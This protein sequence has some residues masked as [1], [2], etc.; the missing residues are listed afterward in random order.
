MRQ[1]ALAILMAQA[2]SFVAA[3]SA[4]FALVDRIF[5]RVGASDNLSRGQS[6]FMLEMNEAANI[7]HN[8]TPKSLVVLDEIGRGTST[9]DGI[10]IAWAIAEHLHR[11]GALTLFA[12][13]YHE[14][15]ELAKELPRLKNF[16]MAIREAGEHLVFTRKLVPGEADKSYGVHVARLAGLPP[17]VIDRANE[18]MDELVSGSEGVALNVP[19]T[20]APARPATDPAAHARQQLSFLA[21]AHPV[22][23]EL[24]AADLDR[25]SP[26]DALTLLHALKNKLD[27]GGQG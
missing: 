8:A 21:D 1:V 25:T 19:G 5:T 17:S 15:T 20:G 12:T 14:L 24:R 27:K 7:L 22:L 9:Y 11:L 10:S 18:V 4:E 3:E 16:N 26:L 2:G 13:H 23:E 6:T